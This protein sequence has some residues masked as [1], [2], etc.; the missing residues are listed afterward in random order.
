MADSS[1]Y[2][3]EVIDETFNQYNIEYQY[4]NE[5]TDFYQ[6]IWCYFHRSNLIY[7]DVSIK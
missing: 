4:L 1:Q 2:Y 3:D 6:E 7:N 5:D